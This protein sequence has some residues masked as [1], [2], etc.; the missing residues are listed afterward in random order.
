[1]MSQNSSYWNNLGNAI[2]NSAISDFCRYRID[3]NHILRQGNYWYDQLA[4]V[5]KRPTRGD[6]I[7]AIKEFEERMSLL[8]NGSKS[9]G[10]MVASFLSTD[11]RSDILAGVMVNLMLP[12]FDAALK[13]E[14][15][16]VA[17]LDLTRVAAALAV[18]RAKHGEYPDKLDQ[19]VPT[20]LAQVPD[21]L[22]SGKPFLYRRMPN[23]GYLLYSV[24]ENGTDDRGTDYGGQIV[25]GE[26][27]EEE[28]DDFD[29]QATD[30]VIRVPMPKFELPAKPEF[31]E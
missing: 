27:T 28:D 31:V 10:R 6:R 2:V 4:A 8:R 20:I 19:L 1:M 30:I 3:W 15:R 23:G 5:G 18:Y 7:T 11:A 9:R 16:A 13:H 22:Y 26:W 12:A 25:E 24:F 29:Y 17:L 21:D 14:D